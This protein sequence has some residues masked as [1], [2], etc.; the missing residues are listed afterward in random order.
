MGVPGKPGEGGGDS[1]LRWPLRS[2]CLMV[3]IDPAVDVTVLDRS[4]GDGR[5]GEGLST[6]G[7]VDSGRGTRESKNPAL[8][9]SDSGVAATLL[10]SGCSPSLEAFNAEKM[11]SSPRKLCRL[12]SWLIVLLDEFADA[13]AL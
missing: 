7:A 1:S 5:T 10:D 9:F 3:R 6:V 2:D 11:D 12:A 13:G 4:G 8:C